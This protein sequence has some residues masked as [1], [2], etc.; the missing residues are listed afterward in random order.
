LVQGPGRVASNAPKAGGRPPRALRGAQTGIL[1]DRRPSTRG[2]A[3]GGLGD[4]CCGA[5][6]APISV[7]KGEARG[8]VFAVDIHYRW[9]S[10]GPE[11]TSPR[12]EGGRA[13]LSSKARVS[14]ETGRH[15]TPERY[16][17]CCSLGRAGDVVLFRAVVE[18]SWRVSV[19]VCRASG[20]RKVLVRPGCNSRSPP[21]SSSAGRPPR[22]VDL[23][24]AGRSSGRQTPQMRAEPSEWAQPTARGRVDGSR[25][26]TWASYRARRG[27]AIGGVFHVRIIG[28]NVNR[29]STAWQ[30]QAHARWARYAALGG[31]RMPHTF[32]RPAN[33]C[34]DRARVGEGARPA[35][36][37]EPNP[38]PNAAGTATRPRASSTGDQD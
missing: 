3:G 35:T 8:I 12:P 25:R 11:A 28:T 4:G 14:G 7:R 30:T 21:I 15:T 18:G 19:G 2:G 5:P 23:R 34:S 27:G 1:G 10:R 26:G 9:P 33:R 20:Y 16:G 29:V 24:R 31:R 36:C 38:L 6:P 17:A 32:A 37:K 13:S 22:I